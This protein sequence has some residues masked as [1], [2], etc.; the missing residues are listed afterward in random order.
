MGLLQ[1]PRKIPYILHLENVPVS[2]PVGVSLHF[3][4]KVN[5]NSLVRMKARPFEIVDSVSRAQLGFL[6]SCV[7][8]QQ[9]LL[10]Y[11]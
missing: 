11:A 1:V 5:L 4:N 10:E 2:D 7:E 6:L 3:H 8:W 9:E